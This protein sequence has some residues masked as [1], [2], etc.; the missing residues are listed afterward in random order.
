MALTSALSVHLVNREALIDAG[1]ALREGVTVTTSDDAS[2]LVPAE[3][4]LAGQGWRANAAGH[5][6]AVLRSP[7][8]GLVYYTLRLVLDVKQALWALFALQVMLFALAVALVPSIGLMLDVPLRQSFV[9]GV[10]VAAMPTFSGFLSYTLTEGLV[11]SL[12][13]IYLYFAIRAKAGDMKSMLASAA[14][15][16]I[17][18]IVRPPMLVWSLSL[19]PALIFVLRKRQYAMV[20]MC[21][22]LATSPMLLWQYRGYQITG[23]VIGL[24][25]IYHWDSNDLYRPI[26]GEVWRFHKM[27]GQTGV[28]FHRDMNA[29]WVAA[30][31]GASG[32]DAVEEVLGHVG[33]EVFTIFE[34]AEVRKAYS[35]YYAIMQAQVPYASTGKAMPAVPSEAEKAILERFTNYG[36][37][38]QHTFPIKAWVKVP[39]R[40][41]FNEMAAHSN[42]SLFMFQST[43]RGK[44]WMEALRY[45]SFALH[46]CLFV[47][48][49]L[50]LLVLFRFGFSRKGAFETLSMALPIALY[51]A[52]LAFVQRGVEER[53]TLPMLIPMLL[54]VVASANLLASNWR[55]RRDLT[56]FT[57]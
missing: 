34:R 41:Y 56:T 6:A 5:A 33:S 1:E 43:H 23:E 20:A 26:H 40:V 15:L 19:L 54:V 37:Q 45:A 17:L 52:Y 12:V 16:G 44:V 51:L 38:Y 21:I 31:E 53:Y 36:K 9:L 29:L 49:P 18:I 46:F 39:A 27:W 8:Y 7:G 2:Y 28:D 22:L 47:F 3:N 14:L 32:E 13:V 57:P 48:F 42:L 55:E 30:Q 24:H 25:P 4:K 10:L 35:D 11:P 50:A